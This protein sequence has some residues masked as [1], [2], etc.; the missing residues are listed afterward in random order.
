MPVVQVVTLIVTAALTWYLA[1]SN[2]SSLEIA[3]TS[4]QTAKLIKTKELCDEFNNIYWMYDNNLRNNHS[5]DLDLL[6]LWTYPAWQWEINDSIKKH[7]EGM[8]RRKKLKQLELN[9][10]LYRLL[11]YFENAKELDKIGYLN[12][13]FFYNFF[14]TT[15]N[16][17]LEKE[18]DSEFKE[19]NPTFIEYIDKIRGFKSDSIIDSPYIWDGFDYCLVN[20]FITGLPKNETELIN[21]FKSAWDNDF[22]KFEKIRKENK[23]ELREDEKYHP[24]I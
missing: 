23:V 3:Q 9:I 21:L 6:H 2:H 12:R 7:W 11:E 24:D 16:R 15:V 14:T 22:S 8:D 20:I 18:N 1:S 19:N 5:H 17:L 4:M 10:E 13:S